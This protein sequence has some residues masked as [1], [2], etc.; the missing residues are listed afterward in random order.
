MRA[1]NG[2]RY[3]G[4]PFTQRNSG[5]ALEKFPQ[6]PILAA[7]AFR[8]ND[9]QLSLAQEADAIPDGGF[10]SA[11]G[12]N[13]KGAVKLQK[14][15][16]GAMSEQALHRHVTIRAGQSR[17]HEKRIEITL[18]VGNNQGGPLDRNVFQPEIF[19]PEENSEQ[20]PQRRLAS[21]HDGVIVHASTPS[22]WSS[23]GPT[24]VKS[25]FSTEKKS[26]AGPHTC[27]ATGL[28]V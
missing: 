21:G 24:S 1:G 10:I 3:D 15:R 2:D 23:R 22:D 6:T 16:N 18:M 27:V 13:G 14:S 17:S 19:D 12:G 5:K 20:Q 28:S 8:K 7:P 26:T 4:D 25:R 11:A 9:Y